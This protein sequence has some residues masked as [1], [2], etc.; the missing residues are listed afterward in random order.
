MSAAPGFLASY[1]VLGEAVVGL[2]VCGRVGFD[3]D[4]FDGIGIDKAIV[5]HLGGFHAVGSQV[6][7]AV[8]S[9]PGAAFCLDQSRSLLVGEEADFEATI[10]TETGIPGEELAGT[11]L[12]ARALPLA[13]QALIQRLGRVA[14]AAGEEGGK[15]CADQKWFKHG[16]IPLSGYFQGVMG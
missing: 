13:E 10:G 7:L 11:I 14:R 5:V 9:R 2:A 3:A 6:V 8:V 1:A 16:D 12:V 4:V 15:A